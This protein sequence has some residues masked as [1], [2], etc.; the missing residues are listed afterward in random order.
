MTDL[1]IEVVRT[2]ERLIRHSPISHS[3]STYTTFARTQSEAPYDAAEHARQG[4]AIGNRPLGEPRQ[5]RHPVANI[6][7]SCR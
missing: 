3:V 4:L 1:R 2:P 5:R 7:R 6:K